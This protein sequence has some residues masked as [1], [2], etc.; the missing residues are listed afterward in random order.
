MKLKK[1][2]TKTHTYSEEK[3]IQLD[4]LRHYRSHEPTETETHQRILRFNI[5]FL[6][7]SHTFTFIL[8][9]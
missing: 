5:A 8:Y 1:I 9:K 4:A 2:V 6:L 7:K 3:S